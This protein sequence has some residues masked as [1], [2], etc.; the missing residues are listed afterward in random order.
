MTAFRT[1]LTV[2]AFF[3]GSISSISGFGIGTILTPFMALQFGV[4]LAV[5]AVS[6]PHCTGNALRFSFGASSPR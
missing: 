1:L 5:A 3:A 6:I 4:K 2:V